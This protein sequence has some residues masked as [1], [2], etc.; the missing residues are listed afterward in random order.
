VTWLEPVNVD[1]PSNDPESG[2][3]RYPGN[4]YGRGGCPIVFDGKTYK[5][6]AEAA[7]AA[8]VNSHKMRRVLGRKSDPRRRHDR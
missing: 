8:G 7:K 4:K 1:L 6:I 5:S 2:F 3:R